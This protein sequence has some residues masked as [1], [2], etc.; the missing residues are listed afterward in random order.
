[1]FGIMAGYLYMVLSIGPRFMQNRAPFQI[2][3]ILIVYNAFQILA[4]V[5]VWFYVS[6]KEKI[7][8]E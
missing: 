3:K 1:M 2:K 5:F 7:F 6:L 4:N 8:D